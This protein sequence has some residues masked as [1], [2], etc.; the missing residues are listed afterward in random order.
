MILGFLA[1][2][3]ILAGWL[4]FATKP[5]LAGNPTPT[6]TNT[7]AATETP[8]NT[9]ATTVLK[10]EMSLYWRVLAGKLDVTADDLLAKANQS[11]VEIGAVETNDAFW[12]ALAG[13]LV[14]I[15]ADD[16]EKKAIE[17]TKESAA[18]ATQTANAA[19]VTATA[20]ATVTQTISATVVVSATPELDL[21]KIV[22]ETVE[23][24]VN[25]KA[26]ALI[27][28]ASQ[29]CVVR[30][31]IPQGTWIGPNDPTIP[32]EVSYD[33]GVTTTGIVSDTLVISSVKTIDIPG[34]GTVVIWHESDKDIT[35][36]GVRVSGT[37]KI[38]TGLPGTGAESSLLIALVVLGIAGLVLFVGIRRRQLARAGVG[39][40]LTFAI[41][42]MLAFASAPASA[43]PNMA[44]P[45]RTPQATATQ[46]ASPTETPAP[47]Q[48][49]AVLTEVPPTAEPQP[50]AEPT[51]STVQVTYLPD[52]NTIGIA[53]PLVKQDKDGKLFVQFD[54]GGNV[55]ET[56][57]N[58]LQTKLTGFKIVDAQMRQDGRLEVKDTNKPA[59]WR[60]AGQVQIPEVTDG[61][62]VT[63][64]AQDG[65]F[66][67]FTLSNGDTHHLELPKGAKGDPGPVGSSFLD[68]WW[69][70]LLIIVLVV[71][72][73]VH[74]LRG[75]TRI[76][77]FRWPRRQPQSMTFPEESPRAPAIV[78][79]SPAEDTPVQENDPY[80]LPD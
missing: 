56:E 48:P 3:I 40:F 47:E 20:T 38:P 73:L 63:D 64:I 67:V 58:E 24:T 25:A 75:H 71:F 43:A 66:V 21:S 61:V 7:A 12:Q 35:I 79:T 9:T 27:E 33:L 62:S 59:E 50:T 29:P 32:V 8:T 39:V 70:V 5:T 10:F 34:D 28:C 80:R 13:K 44:P 4:G 26:S 6:A 11:S 69:W 23:I 68:P 74:L 78:R 14:S 30:L 15:N 46:P 49:T 36:K 57:C 51:E 2:I 31:F 53:L 1:A 17:A 54:C 52:G 16:L 55:Q 76:P 77:L 22:T 45:T 19:T 72:N 42:I 60:S 41:G 65:D 18:A 37:S